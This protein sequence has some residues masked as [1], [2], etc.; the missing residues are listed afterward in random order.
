MRPNIS[1]TRLLASVSSRAP[2]GRVP[3]RGVEA[4]SCDATLGDLL[5]AVV[6][7][8]LAPSVPL[9]APRGLLRAR[10]ALERRCPTL[11]ARWRRATPNECFRHEISCRH[12]SGQAI[13]LT[14]LARCLAA[15]R[16]SSP[17][18]RC[19]APERD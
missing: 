4:G 8:R 2:S 6:I 15:D 17:D 7:S 12:A 14:A 16:H 3:E 9:L 10:A 13:F 18:A 19:A 1:R 5:S 11:L